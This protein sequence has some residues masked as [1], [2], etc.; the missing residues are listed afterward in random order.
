MGVRIVKC[1]NGTAPDVFHN[2]FMELEHG[3]AT[4]RNGLKDA[5]SKNGKCKERDV[6]KRNKAL[7]HFA[8][9]SEN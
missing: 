7:Q 9:I 1:L 8:I 2:Y 5:K 6:L 3:K 4:R